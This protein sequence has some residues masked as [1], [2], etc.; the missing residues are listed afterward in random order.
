[1]PTSSNNRALDLGAFSS[2]EEICLPYK[3]MLGNYIESIERGA[4]TV[5]ITG[6]CGFC[7]YG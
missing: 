4:D 2:P 7:R 1:M 6:N 5:I 3:I